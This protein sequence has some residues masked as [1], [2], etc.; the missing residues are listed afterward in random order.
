M[1]TLSRICLSLAAFLVV[2]GTV[3]GLTAHELAGAT[4]LLVAAAT[5]CFL[6]MVLRTL[7]RGE[8]EQESEE[9]EEVEVHVGPTI[10]PLGFALA[11]TVL[12]LGLIVSPWLLIAGAI[13]FALSAAG[14]LRD[15]ARSRA[16]AGHRSGSLSPGSSTSRRP[17]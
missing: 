15:V 17:R 1:S 6:G 4:E 12:V 10:W 11:G 13:V 5:F 7:A 9:S 2:A 16:H 14:W 3:Y 8:T